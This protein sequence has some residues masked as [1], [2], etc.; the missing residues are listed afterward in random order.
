MILLSCVY[1]L[2]LQLTVIDKKVQQMTEKLSQTV[3]F[4][5]R[6]LKYAAPAEVMVFKQ[7]LE[8]RL[9]VI[10]GYNPDVNNLLGNTYELDFTTGLAPNARQ[11][12]AGVFGHV[13][14]GEG[15]VLTRF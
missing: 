15:N 11:T 8:T 6:L 10:L 5:S 1:H 13:R 7:L 2:Q 14:G 12:V 9:Q 3:E 4:T